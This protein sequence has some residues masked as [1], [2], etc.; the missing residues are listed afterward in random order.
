MEV[1]VPYEK[2][3]TILC[4]GRV[5]AEDASWAGSTVRQQIGRIRHSLKSDRQEIM[6]LLKLGAI[7]LTME[8]AK[9]A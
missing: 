3:A 6:K 7:R 9:E 2:G 1:Q 8:E 5:K 4:I